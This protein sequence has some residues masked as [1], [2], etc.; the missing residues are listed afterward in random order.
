MPDRSSVPGQLHSRSLRPQQLRIHPP[1]KRVP[2]EASKRVVAAGR[3][4]THRGEVHVA[5][6]RQLLRPAP[7]AALPMIMHA[8]S[9]EATRHQITAITQLSSAKIG[10]VGLVPA[11]RRTIRRSMALFQASIRDASHRGPISR[12]RARPPPSHSGVLASGRLHVSRADLAHQVPTR[13]EDV[14]RCNVSPNI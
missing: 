5:K 13:Y 8:L 9:N 2:Y 11:C 3:R 12:G 10:V 14:R 4:R 1:L 7:T 6:T